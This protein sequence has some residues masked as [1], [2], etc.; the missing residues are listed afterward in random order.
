MSY[1]YKGTKIT[2]TSTASK[3]FKKSG[4]SNAKVNQTYFNKSTGHVYTCTT[5]GK[6]KDAKWKYTRTDI[7]AKPKVAVTNLVAPERTTGHTMKTTWK[8]P[9]DL[10]NTKN[11]RRAQGLDIVWYIGI[12]GKDPKIVKHTGNES[13]TTSSINL[14]NLK[15]GNTTYKRASFYP[16]TT[17][18]LE[19]VTVKVDPDNS[20][21][22]GPVAQSTRRFTAPR[23]PSLSALTLDPANGQVSCT[24]TTDPG[25]DYQERYDTRYK[26]TVKDTHTNTTQVISDTSS[27]STEITIT[28]DATGYQALNY[29]EYIQVS[30]EAWARGY[31]GDSGH[32]YATHYVSFP[33]VPSIKEATV[34]SKDSAGKCTLLIDTNEAKEH[35]VD[36]V[37]LEYMA[38]VAYENASD[39]PGGASWESSGIVDDG[40]CTALTIPVAD[41]IPTRGNYTWVR[42]RSWHDNE[43]VLYRYSDYMRL[44]ELTT[45]AATAVDD[46]ITIIDAVAGGDG[47]S[48]VV[49][50]A[51]NKDGTDDSTGT[52]LTWSD[53]ED[54]WKSTE[55]PKKYDF[56]WSDGPIT[57]GA[58]IYNDSAVITIKGL[59]DAT[60]YYIRA[61][62]YL[63]G[64]PTTYSDYSNTA[65]CLTSE[66]P[67]SI[68]ATCDRYV[69][70]GDSL[71]VYWTFA[72]NG[73]Q[74]E[75]QIVQD[76][77]Y[78]LSTD[79]AVNADKAYFELT[80]GEYVRVTPVG[81]ENPSSEG[82]Y[83]QFGGAVI[84]TGQNSLGST[85]IGADR[86][87]TFA[88]NG[89]VSFNVQASTGSGFVTS[90][91]KTV[92][93]IEKPV[94]NIT[95]SSLVHVHEDAEREFTGEI[96]TF[97]PLAG[98]SVK[99]LDINIEPLQDLH[100][101]DKPW[102]GGAGKNKLHVTATTQTINGVTFTVNSD[103]TITANGTA[104]ANVGFQLY[105]GTNNTFDL[106][107]GNY[108][109]T[110]CPTG[111]G[112][113]TYR[114]W[115]DDRNS[116]GT[117]NITSVA[118]AGAGANITI[119]QGKCRAYLVIASGQ[120]LTNKVFY[121]MIRLAS[122]SDATYEPYENI[123]PITGWT[124]CEVDVTG[125]NLIKVSAES[126][127]NSQACTSS[128]TDSGVTV[129]AT[130]NYARR[131]DAFNV[132][133]G[134][135]YTLSFKGK[136]TG[137][138]NNV[139]F[140]KSAGAGG[141]NDRYG[142]QTLTATETE[143]TYTFTA[144]TSVFAIGFY[145]TSNSSSGEMTITD[146]QLERGSTATDYVP[147]NPNSAVYPVS[148]QTEAGTVYG[149]TVD[150]VSGELT[151][152]RILETFTSA[153]LYGNYGD[154]NAPLYYIDRTSSTPIKPYANSAQTNYLASNYFGKT[155]GSSYNSMKNGEIR[156]Q[157]LPQ[158]SRYYF[159]WD[160]ATLAEINSAFT[161]KPLQ[162]C[163]ELATP[164]TYQ[165]DPVQVELLIGEQNNIWNDVDIT[166]LKLA[167]VTLDEDQLQS[168]NLSFTL[169]SD[170]VCDVK[171]L[172]TSQGAVGQFP[173]GV[174]RQ[175]SGDTIYSNVYEP[176]W[177]W[178][179]SLNKWATTIAL[180]T[181]LDFWDLGIYTLS[182]IGIDRATGLNSNEVLWQFTVSWAHQATNPF[183]FVT[184][185]PIDTVDD[186]DYHHQSV[187]I[188]LTP[189]TGSATSDVYDIYRL[190]GDGAKLI[191]QSFPLTYVAMDDY[192]P[193]GDDLTLYYRVA[194]RT[195]DGDVEFADIEYV[196]D[197]SKI[198]FDWSAGTLELP[199]NLS[200]GDKYKKSMTTREHMDGG[201][202]GYWNQNIARTASLNSDVIRL[203]MQD[204]IDA[205]RQLAH[206][207]GPVFVRTPDGSAYEADVQV[208]DMS[209][210][211]TL[212][213]IAIDAT[214]I[215]LTQEFILPT[216]F[217]LESE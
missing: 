150:V 161:A 103:G 108:I 78:E 90:E 181:D 53:E 95:G 144:T 41:L 33:N 174:L 3:V 124:G 77:W 14:D 182:V 149:G 126:Y 12:T 80:G 69:P 96:V 162:I 133:V 82:W 193:F 118:D 116:A 166:E 89:S 57:V 42:L 20:K 102:V 115:V 164:T 154:D 189:P 49:T 62:R 119:T 148:W 110:G 143:Y 117:G 16:L 9:G 134:Q 47:E 106:A 15:I 209:T 120:T 211:G 142:L 39:I 6:P 178:N 160:S 17:K 99:A 100:G 98:E 122:E 129:T 147:Y 206:Y 135:T 141:W 204:E 140:C 45:P 38:D 55:D 87:A 112:S 10:T 163:A 123:C 185:T 171:V 44:D 91:V 114:I 176:E 180:P 131:M 137:N 48:A 8:V 21:G 139:Y 157:G 93:I 111:G 54:C 175:T 158:P 208:S 198:R 173:Q 113:N 210:D 25:N 59:E 136:S 28:Y 207:A 81:T 146:L 156:T 203:T 37:T 58:D 152:D 192:A 202:D 94:I 84:A 26:V 104:T 51:W 186:N 155:T 170:S 101:Y 130:G 70:T 71:A 127:D 183:D 50:L 60:K 105:T 214:E 83:E 52:E 97:E 88:V 23:A 153:T 67:E 197:G 109:L 187:Q 215:D 34:S 61:R 205:A 217:D 24:I 145:V 72:G 172:V 213:S 35:P 63:E 86:L 19:Y 40:Q 36:V 159:R 168:N 66:L 194:I 151:V 22:N 75:W 65:T 200:V 11:G 73:I 1:T 190:N 76:V 30:V 191:G 46:D 107:N 179:N 4:V 13:L 169:G 125:E 177:S 188:Y 165:L 85:Q 27:T 132:V 7:C 195:A 32:V 56:T 64:E 138:N 31:A 79:D 5:A 216:P 167:E 196:Q 29:G 74:R 18:T 201:I 68:V 92:T 212:T 199:Y 43:S 121:P 184:L 2:G 128:I